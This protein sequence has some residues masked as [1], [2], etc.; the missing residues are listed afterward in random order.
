[1]ND[2]TRSAPCPLFVLHPAR[3]RRLLAR[4]ISRTLPQR[5]PAL[6]LMLCV[7]ALLSSGCQRETTVAIPPTPSEVLTEATGYYCGMRLAEHDG[8]KG[9]I[10]LAGR[11][12]PIW[13]SSVRDAI[14][15]LRQPEEPRDIVG[16]WGNDM[17][18]S[19][20][21]DQ[22]D[23]GAWVELREAW[24]VIDSRAHGGMGAPEAV[25]FAERTQAEA[26][27]EQNGGR[28]VRLD[29]IPDA[30]AFGRPGRMSETH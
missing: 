9:Q 1:M 13:F 19:T 29:D 22:P 20:H 3:I 10:R 7:V 5:M 15:F 11:D 26:F 25:P 27:R 23:A 18:R 6:A 16:A 21:W 8:P 12:E 2:Q 24:F 4:G 30:W 17:G 28:V 14:V